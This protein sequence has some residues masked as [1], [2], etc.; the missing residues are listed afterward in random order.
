MS[1][2]AVTG[3]STNAPSVGGKAQLRL[4]VRGWC[5]QGQCQLR[6]AEP[7]HCRHLQDEVPTLGRTPGVLGS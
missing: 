4:H 2:Q 1:F 5:A 3:A 7:S 6:L